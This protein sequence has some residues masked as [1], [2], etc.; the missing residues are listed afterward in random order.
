MILPLTYYGNPI[1]RRRAKEITAI[2]PELIELAHSMIET[3]DA[4]HG[5]GLAA[6]QVG[7][8]IRLFVL[9]NYI[10]NPDGEMLLTNPQFYINPK[11]SLHSQETEADTEGCLSIPGI[12]SSVERPL[13]V[14]VEAMDLNGEIFIEEAVGYKARVI[15]HENDHINGVLFIDR[16]PTTERSKLE[17]KLRD[18]KKKYKS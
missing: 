5:I 1:L 15:M 14:T 3:M 7:R 6:P 4:N 18:L 13:R 8:E 11:L 9:R 12:R 10:V 2:T 16:I 17:P